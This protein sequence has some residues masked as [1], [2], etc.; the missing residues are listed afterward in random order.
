[1]VA[2]E[3]ITF[4]H[5]AGAATHDAIN[6]RRNAT[7]TVVIP[8]WR[9]FISVN[10]EDSPA[11]YAIAPTR[12]NDISILVSLSSTDPGMAF[13]EVRVEHHVKARPVNFVN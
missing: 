2:I 5:N 13:I 9:R 3:A 6:I 10:P 12:G 7:A 8:E 4:N 1:M 11:A